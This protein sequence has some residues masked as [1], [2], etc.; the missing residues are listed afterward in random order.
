MYRCF[1]ISLIFRAF[2]TSH[3]AFPPAK[4]RNL[5][6]R[7]A[8]AP[9]FEFLVRSPARKKPMCLMSLVSHG[10]SRISDSRRS[11][12][13]DHLSG[14]GRKRP[15]VDFASSA[16]FDHL[17]REWSCSHV[18]PGKSQARKRRLGPAKIGWLIQPGTVHQH[19]ERHL[20]RKKKERT[21]AVE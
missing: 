2:S 9:L 6:K 4:L 18:R 1:I 8:R 14:G 21:S 11:A 16:Y 20:S 19:H 13:F 10:C 17:L 15:S 12:Y 7:R 5:E 3:F